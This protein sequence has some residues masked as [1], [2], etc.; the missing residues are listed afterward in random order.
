VS[1]LDLDALRPELVRD[2]PF[3]WASIPRLVAPDRAAELR[4]SFPSEDFWPNEGEDGEKTYRF[5]L[6]PLLTQEADR[7]APLSPIAD[8][9]HRLAAELVAPEFRGA[10]GRMLGMRVHECSVE[11]DLFR[12]GSE[13]WM[14]PHRDLP[15]KLASLIVY[16]NDDGWDP[17]DGGC[18]R[19]LR[20]RDEADVVTEVPPEPGTGALVVRS[21]RSWHSVTRLRP[22]IARDRISFQVILWRPEHDSSNWTIDQDTGAVTAGR[23]VYNGSWLRRAFTRLRDGR[24][25]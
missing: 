6:R 12:F 21:R 1:L 23:R 3:R 18:L 4:A 22:H 25:G 2:T 10:M 7:V 13:D 15:A 17:V 19:I 11:A 20:S 14:G 9:W 5:R 24:S 16:L 8:V